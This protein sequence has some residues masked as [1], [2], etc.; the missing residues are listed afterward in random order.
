MKIHGFDHVEWYVGD[1]A[2][3]SATLCDAYGFAVAGRSPAGS[4]RHSVLLRQ[5]QI[6]LLLTTPAVGDAV[7]TEYLA[8]HG[9][10]I[11]VIAFSTD[12]VIRAFTEI[13]AA[14]ASPVAEPTFAGAGSDRLRTAVV[15][16]FGDVLHKLV[17]RAESD[18][19]CAP[20]LVELGP[21]RH[22]R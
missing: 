15:S 12:D 6:K 10:G 4:G 8:K 1:L 13:V 18:G 11:A 9:D 5:G 2:V 7:L 19:E 20:G 21:G 16:G 14:G 17:A 3:V 22:P